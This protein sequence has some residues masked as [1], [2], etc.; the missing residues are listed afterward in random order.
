MA[1]LKPKNVRTLCVFSRIR[2]QS[3]TAVGGDRARRS[4]ALIPRPRGLPQSLCR[5]E[6]T[7]T[8]GV[9]PFCGEGKGYLWDTF[10]VPLPAVQESWAPAPTPLGGPLTDVGMLQKTADSSL[11]L[12]LL[13][14]W[15]Q[16]GTWHHLMPL[17]PV[18]PQCPTARWTGRHH[19]AHS[20]G[21]AATF[22]SVAP[23]D[24]RLP[25]GPIRGCPLASTWT[26][27][28]QRWG[29]KQLP[30][31]GGEA[32]QRQEW[33]FPQMIQEKA[34]QQ[35]QNGQH[36][37]HPSL[38]CPHSRLQRSFQQRPSLFFGGGC[39][40]GRAACRVCDSGWTR[41]ERVLDPPLAPCTNLQNTG[42]H[43][44]GPW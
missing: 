7:E 25:R 24:R 34:I 19:G 6:E 11:P 33:K 28:G 2:A 18:A 41:G 15:G 8:L 29:Q 12:Q 35:P 14:I 38:I 32:L 27:G 26:P 16:K 39:G 20:Q 13:V 23:A 22:H 30:L 43:L 44:E 5:K 21:V 1:L 9:G 17:Q 31:P 36:Q 10:G 40:A 37:F 4:P 42:L 3:Y